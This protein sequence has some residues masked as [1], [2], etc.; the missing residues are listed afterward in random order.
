MNMAERVVIIVQARMSSSRLPGKVLLPILGKSLLCRMI[1]RLKMIAH[2][3]QIVIATSCEKEDDI[4][5]AESA[6]MG[7]PCFRGSLNNLLDRHYQTAKKYN[8]DIVLKIPSDCPLI[9]PRIID[10]V[11]NFYFDHPGE[12]DFVSNLHPATFPDGNDV[13]IM[14]SACLEKTW[15]EAT[16]QLEL[17]HTTPY[18]W[19]N[20]EKFRIGNVLYNTGKDYSM[21][22]RFTIDY[23][24]DYEFIKAVF[25][26]LYPV[27]PDFSCEDIL[28]LLEKKPAIYQINAAFSGVNW[29]RNHLDELKTV[30]AGQTKSLAG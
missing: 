30:T 27:K 18:I 4:I 12:Y 6:A 20:P 1:E 21:S 13:E 22:H 25:E 15:Q 14:T 24:E 2:Q 5:E 17:E 9:D 7:V 29:Y 10:Q 11:L 23:Q 28:N 8:A 3:A 16:R 19:E 26:E